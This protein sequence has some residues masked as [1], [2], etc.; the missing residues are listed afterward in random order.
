MAT[1]VA[2]LILTLGILGASSAPSSA[3][4]GPTRVAMV[5]KT[6][7]RLKRAEHLYKKGRYQ[8]A[9]LACEKL[10][11]AAGLPREVEVRCLRL[12]AL[13]PRALAAC[14]SLPGSMSG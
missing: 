13:H 11:T 12:E 5:K 6:D 14:K 3:R 7:T 10:R 8:E 4:P 9:L 2:S 1:A